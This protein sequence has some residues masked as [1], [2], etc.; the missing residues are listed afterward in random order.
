MKYIITESQVDV[1]KK[2]MYD[3]L[4]KDSKSWDVQYF[5]FKE[6]TVTDESGDVIFN[7]TTNNQ[8]YQGETSDIL[9]ISHKLVNKIESFLPIM[10]EYYISDWFS[11]K[12]KRRVDEIGVTYEEE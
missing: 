7:Y 1:M 2:Y 9:I 6:M 11:E 4:D 12:Y 5:N 10:D 3:I 8:M